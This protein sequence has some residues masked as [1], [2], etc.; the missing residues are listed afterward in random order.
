MKKISLQSSYPLLLLAGMAA[1]AI[2]GLFTAGFIYTLRL[3][4]EVIWNDIPV[5]LD[6]SDVYGWYVVAICTIGGLL[7]GLAVKL[8]G[9]YPTSIEQA[10]E[11]FKKTKK[12]DYK[13]IWQAAIISVISLG[14]GASLGPEAALTALIGGLATLIAL[15][16]KHIETIQNIKLGKRKGRI[17]GLAAAA[18]GY[19]AFSAV[20]ISDNYFQ[21]TN[22]TYRFVFS[23]MLWMFAV[24]AL[25]ILAG[26]LY[27]WSERLF[28]KLYSP[29]RK[30]NTVLATTAGG[31]MLGMLAY[32]HPDVLFSGHEDL[33]Y[34]LGSVE[35]NGLWFF[36]SLAIAK[37]AATT[38]CLATGWKGGRFLP[39]LMVGAAIGLALASIAGV[40]PMFAM[41]I[42]MSAALSFVLKRPLAAGLLVACFF[43]IALTIQIV[44]AA[45]VVSLLATRLPRLYPRSAEV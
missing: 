29:S 12:F 31:L 39:I 26:G 5:A 3:A 25:G 13:H 6:I 23:D 14:F 2:A 33:G 38:I 30:L 11:Q 8:L 7:V 17:L 45:F 4:Q 20:S 34:L 28:E 32:L 10:L 18:S 21:I 43:P 41:A 44:L 27:L 15:R 35:V 42:G 1:G 40:T 37:I 16:L 19:L 9:D 24:I 22:Q 36:V